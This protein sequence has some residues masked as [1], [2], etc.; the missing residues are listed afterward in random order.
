MGLFWDYFK[1][2]LRW[3]LLFRAGPLSCL[4][5]GASTAL[6]ASRTVISSLRDQF[7]PALCEDR[8]LVRFANSRGIV[9]GALETDAGWNARVKTAYLFWSRS[10]RESSMAEM[11]CKGFGFT[12]VSVAN[13][14]GNH[15]LTDET[16]G[17]QLTDETSHE[18]LEAI[19]SDRWAE[20]M[21]T[22]CLSSDAQEYLKEQVKWCINEVK[23]A[24]S[25]LAGVLYIAPLYDEISL[26]PLT[27]ETSHS[28][29]FDE[30]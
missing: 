19:E 7:L 28:L 30:R 25:K 24:R 5:E 15:A 14:A 20:F 21:V 13:L 18:I 29:L 9:R 16:G 26:E 27:D 17:E 11:L 23:P 12:S 6:D 4:V 8:F 22:I 1:N 3:P 2:D 10:G